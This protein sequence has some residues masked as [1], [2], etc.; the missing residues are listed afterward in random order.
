MSKT[1]LYNFTDECGS[2]TQNPSNNH[3]KTHPFYV[4]ANFIIEISQYFELEERINEIK[5]KYNVPYYVEVKWAHFSDRLKKKKNIPHELTTDEIHSFIKEVIECVCNTPSAKLYFTFTDNKTVNRIDEI[6]LIRMHIQNAIQRAQSEAVSNNGYAVIIADDM[7]SSNKKLKKVFQQLTIEGDQYTQY[8]NVQK[9]LLIDY[10]DLSC[11]LQIADLF[12]GVLTATLKYATSPD[13]E[14]RRFLFGFD[15]FK[16]TLYKIIRYTHFPNP[17][18]YTSG[19]KEIPSGCGK[20]LAV[21][22]SD[23]LESK[24]YQEEV[25]PYLH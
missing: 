18:V 22:V 15:L 5:K 24:I 23:I 11:G 25:Q 17:E 4:R 19:I 12:A 21:E 16:K 6:K 14:K 9:G 1:I 7:N 3:L 13:T 20:E 10:S 2:Y 8:P